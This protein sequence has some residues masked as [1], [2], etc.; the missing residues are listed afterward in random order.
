MV[1]IAKFL[2]LA[3]IAAILI[4][5][6]SYTEIERKTCEEN[7]VKINTISEIDSQPKAI[8]NKWIKNNSEIKI[9]LYG[10]NFSVVF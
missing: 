3:S 5:F 9:Q 7:P 10:L 6:I 8:D 4:F 2:C 1:K